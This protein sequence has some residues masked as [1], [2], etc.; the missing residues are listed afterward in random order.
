YPSLFS[1]SFFNNS[2]HS[3]SD[4]EIHN[5]QSFSPPSFI[6]LMNSPYAACVC[7]LVLAILFLASRVASLFIPITRNGTRNGTNL[8]A[9]T[10]TPVTTSDVESS[11]D[12]IT[13]NCI[14]S[15]KLSD[16]VNEEENVEP[17]ES[18]ADG[19]PDAKKPKSWE[20]GDTVQHKNEKGVK[21]TI[22]GTKGLGDTS[23]FYVLDPY[24]QI[25]LCKSEK[26]ERI[27]K[28]N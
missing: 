1:T 6:L 9:A 28:S 8:V 21:L 18:Q 24:K 4:S 5:W 25:Y 14:S 23:A 16:D 17:L 7:I 19:D 12:P 3:K 26:L 11:G 13:E 20:K 10:S 22:V 27:G 15:S 2:P